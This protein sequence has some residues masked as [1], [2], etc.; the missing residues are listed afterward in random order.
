MSNILE[1]LDD[2]VEKTN[3]LRNTSAGSCLAGDYEDKVLRNQEVIMKALKVLLAHKNPGMIL[4][5]A[6]DDKEVKCGH[7]GKNFL[8]E[9]SGGSGI[10]HCP[11]CNVALE[12]KLPKV[13]KLPHNCF[14]RSKDDVYIAECPECSEK[15]KFITKMRK[16]ACLVN[17]GNCGERFHIRI[18]E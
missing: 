8:L 7:C 5:K 14:R 1:L 10:T 15:T 3:T 2:A 16:D 13:G 12:F 6:I 17:C 4:N 11:H 18:V 9:Y